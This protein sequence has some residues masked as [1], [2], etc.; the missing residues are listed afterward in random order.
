MKK[1]QLVICDYPDMNADILFIV[2]PTCTR[3]SYIAETLDCNKVIIN[4]DSQQVYKTLS[5]LRATPTNLTADHRLYSYIEDSEFYSVGIWLEHAVKEIHAA[6]AKK[7][8]PI[9]VGGTAFYIYMLLAG[10]PNAP[11]IKIDLTK[12]T[13]IELQQIAGNKF[14]DRYRL[15]RAAGVLLS[16]GKTIEEWNTQS[17]APNLGKCKIYCTQKPN[18]EDLYYRTNLI[19]KASIYEELPMCKNK[20][21]GFDEIQLI[22]KGLISYN[23]ALEKMVIRTRQ[24]AKR[25]HTF[26]KKILRDFA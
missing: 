25:Q 15:E 11:I 23:E 12:Y 14:V 9:I 18:L 6:W 10:P 19:L 20:P 3:K 2:G 24:Y 13:N 16:T 21:I 4:C 7:K 5:Q 22:Q 17:Y 1:N 8:L 26:F